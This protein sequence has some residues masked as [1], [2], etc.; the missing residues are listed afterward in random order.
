[1]FSIFV[2]VRA[3]RFSSAYI[4]EFSYCIVAMLALVVPAMFW[5]FTASANMASLNSACAPP[6]WCTVSHSCLHP[7]AILCSKPVICWVPSEKYWPTTWISWLYLASVAP[8]CAYISAMWSSWLNV[9]DWCTEN[10]RFSMVMAAGIAS[11]NAARSVSGWE[12]A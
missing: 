8:N 10:S 1:M 5:H 7:L 9:F 2:W 6:I 12:M 4:A 11:I 3:W